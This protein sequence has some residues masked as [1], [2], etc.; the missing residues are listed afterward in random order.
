MPRS[1]GLIL[2]DCAVS[3]SV[4]QKADGSE[5]VFGNA[6]DYKGRV[7][8]LS[9]EESG[10]KTNLKAAGD[11]QKKH[12]FHS[13]G[14][15]LHLKGFVKAVGYF[16]TGQDGVGLLHHYIKVEHRPLS[17]MQSPYTWIGVIEKWETTGSTGE[18]QMENI[19]CDLTP[20]YTTA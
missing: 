17:T 10:E 11:V 20:D 7:K 1:H 19:D 15:T 13:E 5:P 12:R 6:A 4:G 2:E 3:I 14:G 8:E 16:F 18:G 9:I